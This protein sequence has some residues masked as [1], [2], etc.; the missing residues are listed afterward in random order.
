MLE[1]FSICCRYYFPKCRIISIEPFPETYSMLENNVKR[2][3]I[4]TINVPFGDGSKLLLINP[5][6]GNG[7]A[8]CFP[9]G[10]TKSWTLKE[11]FNYF[12]LDK[13][14]NFILKSDCEGGEKYFLHEDNIKFLSLCKFF[15]SEFHKRHKNSDISLCTDGE[16]EEIINI[17]KKTHNYKIE[18]C[19]Y[20]EYM[21]NLFAER[22]N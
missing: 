12:K 19:A 4:E 21:F 9:N 11:I 22:K 3:K 20:D 18:Q 16:I 7:G 8:Q 10:D 13:N 15:T 14:K 1:F 5:H 2:L 6:K 17:I